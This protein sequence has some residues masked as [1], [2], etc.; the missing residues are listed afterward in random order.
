MSMRSLQIL[1]AEDDPQNQAM[2]KL[3][4]V[5]RGHRVKSV[6]SGIQALEA[7]KLE[8][9][10]LVLMD[11]QMPEMGGLEATRLI[12]EWENSQRHVLI[13]ILSASVPT[14]VIESYKSFG[15]DTFL[16]KPFD[17]KRLDLLLNLI[18]N[19]PM[20]ATPGASY[21]DMDAPLHEL[22][23]LDEQE[24]LSRFD[25]DVQLFHENLAEF[26]K[27]LPARLERMQEGLTAQ[28]WED[29]SIQ[30]H[31]LKG[32]AAN[33]GALQ[34]SV[35]AY[36]LDEYSRQKKTGLTQKTFQKI[37]QHLPLLVESARK[38]VNQE[39]L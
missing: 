26:L 27:G 30:A 15:A 3:L 39:R 37:T 22:P 19:E 23:L 13:A 4:L 29:L 14:Q 33:F 8:N 11:I 10:D 36:R 35:L 16:T 21:Y 31:N 34:L 38:I 5:R 6:W 28:K 9:F 25:G 1:V 2:M 17:L 20:Q 7:V 12:R 24:A 32:V 18:A